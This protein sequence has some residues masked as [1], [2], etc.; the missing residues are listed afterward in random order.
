M[1]RDRLK[2]ETK[3]CE[4]INDLQKYLESQLLADEEL[5]PITVEEIC[6]VYLRRIGHLYYK[7]CGKCLT[8]STNFSRYSFFF[9]G[10]IIS[11]CTNH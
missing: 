4:I 2:D 6:R 7:V 3:V 5:S 1:I 8:N 10:Y 11:H 9:V